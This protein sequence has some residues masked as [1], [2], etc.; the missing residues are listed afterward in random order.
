MLY[1]ENFQEHNFLWTQWKK[2]RHFDYLK[3][4]TGPVENEV[5][6]HHNMTSELSHDEDDNKK[7]KKEKENKESNSR[8]NVSNTFRIYAKLENN[9]HLSNKYALFYNM[10]KYYKAF[11]RD[12]FE[13]LPITFHIRKGTK[14]LEFMKF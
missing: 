2:L 1:K 11:S 13:V 3:K 12:P 8:I 9:Y 5:T 7:R 14:D 6:N 10:R 4:F